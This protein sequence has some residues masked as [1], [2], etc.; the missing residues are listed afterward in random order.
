MGFQYTF[1]VSSLEVLLL[2][3]LRQIEAT[4]KL[5]RN[6]LRPVDILLAEKQEILETFDLETRVQKV[7]EKLTRQ[8][9]VLE[10]DEAGLKSL[11]SRALLIQ[12]LV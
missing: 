6:P 1:P 11:E 12:S 3:G 7:T 10:L 2:D 9:K 5:A 8:I 4:K